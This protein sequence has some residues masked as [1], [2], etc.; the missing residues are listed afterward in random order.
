MRLIAQ[1]QAVTDRLR[2]WREEM[3][4]SRKADDQPGET[5]K[6]HPGKLSPRGG[7]K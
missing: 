5:P 2:E 4:R 7:R 6:T 3:A 1:E